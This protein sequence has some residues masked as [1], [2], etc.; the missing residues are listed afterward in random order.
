MFVCCVCCVLCR[1]RPLRRADH[2]F[3]GVLLDVCVCVCVC[4][5]VCDIETSTVRWPGSVL[6]CWRHRKRKSTAKH[7]KQPVILYQMCNF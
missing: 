7:S 4:L 1:W 3:R 5:I 6:G 2:S